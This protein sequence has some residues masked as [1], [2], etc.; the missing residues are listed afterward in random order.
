MIASLTNPDVLKSV[1][2]S[3]K[4]QAAKS[5]GQNFLICEEVID[6]VLLGLTGAP[7]NITELGPGLGTLTQ[8]LIA[9]DYHV[10]GIEKDDEFVH[11]LPTMLPPKLR[12]NLTVI[13]G[14]L[15]EV[16]WTW[17]SSAKA[18]AGDAYSL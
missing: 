6:A 10:R 14:D 16:D 13:H 9:H 3:N 2:A 5:L 12:D 15:K 1:L 8:G 18:S 11:I 4:I 7:K 17:P